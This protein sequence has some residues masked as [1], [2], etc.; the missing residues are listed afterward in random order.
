MCLIQIGILGLGL[1]KVF[2]NDK[3]IAVVT[4]PLTAIMN[5]KLKNCLVKTA[6][7]SMRGKLKNDEADVDEEVELNC[8]ETDVLNG[9][10]PVLIG[11]PESWGSARGQRL[12]LEMKR[13][14]MILLIGID[15][16][17]QGQVCNNS[18]FRIISLI[19]GIVTNTVA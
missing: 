16:F 17:H 13:R 18:F 4:Q 14:D 19:A 8:L 3:G 2:G 12:L 9:Q 11:H 15:E 10:Y 5:E 1:R 6:V 7:L